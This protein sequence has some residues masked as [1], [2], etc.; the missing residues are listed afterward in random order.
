M[1]VLAIDTATTDLVTGVVDTATDNIIDGVVSDTRAHNEQ[2]VPTV[3]H[4][5]DDAHLTFAGLDAVVVGCG[6]GP[7][8]GLRVGMATGQAIAQA[9]GIP[10]YGVCSHDAMA[11]QVFAAVA[12][13]VRRVLIA[14]DA[15]RKE[16]Y[17]AVYERS[18]DGRVNRVAGPSVVKPED[19]A[20]DSE[21][22]AVFAPAPIGERL[23]EGLRERVVGEVT[24]RAAQLVA[25]ADLDA[26]PKGP[27][28]PYY[29]R[30]PDAKEPPAVRPSVALTHKSD[31][32]A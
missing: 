32:D 3:E 4:V 31:G 8:T 2:L 26:A 7:F 17:F 15:R 27:L 12:K 11:A 30:R 1:R 5:L 18:A 23:S 14:S 19:F 22:D 9:R 21:I 25:A 20:T 29:L 6:P 24:P 16:M 13:D 10:C 28:E